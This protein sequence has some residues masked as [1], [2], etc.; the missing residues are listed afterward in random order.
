MSLL[1][2]ALE[3]AEN[4][5]FIFPCH[6]K[7]YFY[8]K[9]G[10]EIMM[11]EK[12]PRVK[13]GLLEAT[14]NIETIEKWWKRWPDAGIGC[15]CGM[16]GII[17]VDVDNKHKDKNG[18]LSLA[19]IGLDFND[20]T[21]VLTPNRGM[22]IYFKG[23]TDSRQGIFPGIDIRSE[24]GYV[25]LPPSKL[26]SNGKCYV[27][28]SFP[29][30]PEQIDNISEDLEKKF[31]REEKNAPQENKEYAPVT[32]ELVAR[33]L[34]NNAMKKYADE[35]ESWIRIGMSLR[36]FK[37]EG[38]KLWK[39]WSQQSD[40]YKENECEA[41]WNSFKIKNKT[42]SIGTLLWYYKQTKEKACQQAFIT[43]Y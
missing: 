25:L 18:F 22:H 12:S 7:D 13:D 21:S 41:K 27:A 2:Q 9:D 1:Q 34:K 39:E 4:G 38:F 28:I 35:Y 11:T 32:L 42:V 37:H 10:K 19:K 14:T 16:T 36:E 15:N 24:G 29:R 33:I 3:Y 40:K 26:F 6:E 8:V 17:V 5:W 20:K 31:A 30:K 23:I 43:E